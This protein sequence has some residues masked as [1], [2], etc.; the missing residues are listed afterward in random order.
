MATAQKKK[1][2]QNKALAKKKKGGGLA[3]GG[4]SENRPDFVPETDNEPMSREELLI[5][6]ID[7]AQALSPQLDEDSEAYMPDL[8]QGDLFNTATGAIYGKTVR[9]VSVH[10]QKEYLLFRDRQLGGGFKG[11]F[12]SEVEAQE[13]IDEDG[14]EVVLSLSNLIFIV[15][16]DGEKQDLVFLSATKTKLK[17][18]RKMN[19]YIQMVRAPRYATVFELSSIKDE[20]PKGS[21]Y[22]FSIRPLGW[23]SDRDTFEEAREVAEA[24]TDKRFRGDHESGNPGSDPKDY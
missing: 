22:N 7:V 15:D 1:K 4:I 5:P 8:K 9:F 13:A 16:E 20:S 11:S 12:S 18:A 23:L 10:Y 24:M 19:T 17:A 2:K 3:K 21:F 14:L 6:R